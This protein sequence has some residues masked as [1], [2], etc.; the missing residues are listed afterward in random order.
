MNVILP[1]D[2]FIWKTA[3]AEVCNLHVK[4]KKEQLKRD[5]CLTVKSVILIFCSLIRLYLKL[6]L[7]RILFFQKVCSWFNNREKC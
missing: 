5:N 6:F 3:S 4:K 2:G 1:K 7:S